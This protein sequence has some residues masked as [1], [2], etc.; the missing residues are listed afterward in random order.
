MALLKSLLS[1][2]EDYDTEFDYEE[3][4]PRRP[5]RADPFSE[6]E[7]GTHDPFAAGRVPRK[8]RVESEDRATMDDLVPVRRQRPVQPVGEEAPVRRQRPVQ[9]VGEEA[10]V[11]RKRPVEAAAGETPVRRQRPVQ[12]VGEETPVRRKRPV[13]VP[14]EEAPV[15]RQRPAAPA[16]QPAPVKK[17]A[18]PA[19]KAAAVDDFDLDAIM[20]EF[21]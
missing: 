9:P 17:P 18:A 14:V 11:R 6:P 13:E 7:E 10:P 4:R 12:P 5:R 19:P 1:R 3:E 21:K 16:A 2:S 8:R 15:R 20:A